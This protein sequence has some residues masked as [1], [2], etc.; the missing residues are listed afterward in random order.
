LTPYSDSA[1][2]KS[3]A[4]SCLHVCVAV[5]SQSRRDIVVDPPGAGRTLSPQSTHTSGPRTRLC[6]QSRR[7]A[8]SRPGFV[9]F[10]FSIA[11]A[12]YWSNVWFQSAAPIRSM[13]LPHYADHGRR[14]K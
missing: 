11:W 9:P 4:V 6:A 5:R 13:I 2:L 10:A 1:I 3:R 12:A 8:C 7:L 14:Q